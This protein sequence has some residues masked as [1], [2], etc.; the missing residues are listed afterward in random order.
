MLN[1]ICVSLS[2]F[3]D[4]RFKFTVSVTGNGY[5]TLAVIAGNGL[6]A[7]TVSAVSGVVAENRVFLSL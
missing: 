7:I 5:F 4:F 1:F 2:F 3:D 6:F